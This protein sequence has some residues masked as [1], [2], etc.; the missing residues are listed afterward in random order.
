MTTL[1]QEYPK[2]QARVRELLG[3]YQ[4]LGMNGAFAASC[5]EDVL[6]R[7]DRA[8]VAGDLPE[9]IRCFDE[10]KGCE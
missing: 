8:A 2:Q 7:A 10:M 5:L 6:Q 9:M 4:S 1:G 3:Q